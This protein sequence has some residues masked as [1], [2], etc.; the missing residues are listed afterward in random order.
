[1]NAVLKNRDVTSSGELGSVIQEV[2]HY[3]TL[4]EKFSSVHTELRRE[5]IVR[6]E[7]VEEG[8]RFVRV[9]G[10]SISL[11]SLVFNEPAADADEKASDC[12]LACGANEGAFDEEELLRRAVALSLEQT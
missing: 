5:G 7:V 3:C 9:T 8:L 2:I 4:R 6:V 12:L 11:E 1:M 10:C